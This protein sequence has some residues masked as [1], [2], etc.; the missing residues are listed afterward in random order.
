MGI[1]STDAFC[2]HELGWTGGFSASGRLG[3]LLNGRANLLHRNDLND[4]TDEELIL[5]SREQEDRRNACLEVLYGRHYARVA[6]WCLRVCGEPDRA[7]DLAQEVFLRL[8]DRLDSF[9]GDSRFSTWLYTLTR[10]VAL[11]R[12]SDAHSRRSVQPEEGLVESSFDPE[13]SAEDRLATEQLG[14]RLREAMS[15]DLEPT[16]SSVLYLHYVEGM[17][18]PAITELMG[19]E[20]KSGA[21]ALVVSGRRK[22]H[23][24]FGRWL[25]RQGGV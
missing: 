23:R 7:S 3:G 25:E 24:R 21:K 14:M 5:L 11:N 16:E 6:R 20:N 22:L 8:H 13:P 19:L 9:R 2:I 4:L 17:T 1:E 10:R 15:R 18:L 12:V